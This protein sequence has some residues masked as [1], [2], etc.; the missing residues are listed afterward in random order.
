MAEENL[1]DKRIAPNPQDADNKTSGPA[2][3][4]GPRHHGVVA[5]IVI[6]V[7]AIAIA[8]CLLL[9]QGCA[10]NPGAALQSTATAQP[11]PT[12]TA[13]QVVSVDDFVVV[14]KAY[15]PDVVSVV[16]WDALGT[17]VHGSVGEEIDANALDAALDAARSVMGD[18]ASQVDWDGARSTLQAILD[19]GTYTVTDTG[20]GSVVITSGSAAEVAAQEGSSSSQGSSSAGGN[21]SSS[22]TSGDYVH[23]SVS[24]SSDAAGGSVSGSA[25][26]TFAKGATAYDALCATGLSVNAS[27]TQYGVYVSAIG[28]LAEKQYGGTSGWLYAVNGSTPG[29]ACS[30]YVLSDGDSVSWYYT[31]S[32]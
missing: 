18:S 26:P 8:L 7:A 1:S 10:G 19:G 2:S 23:V 24:V 15:S 20:N 4:G 13:Q 28:G 30:S 5:V 27:R 12:S 32:G 3:T 31:T 29:I 25:S 9:R 14:L 6:C 21:S 16:D 11:T 17:K 22:T